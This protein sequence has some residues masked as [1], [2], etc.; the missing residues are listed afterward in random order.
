MSTSEME[1]TNAPSRS[2]QNPPMAIPFLDVTTA[3]SPDVAIRPASRISQFGMGYL[4][5]LLDVDRFIIIVFVVFL[6]D[7]IA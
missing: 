3:M 6:A 7:R 2:K 1:P 5:V 4:C